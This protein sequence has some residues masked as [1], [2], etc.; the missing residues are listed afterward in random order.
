MRRE[1]FRSIGIDDN[2]FELLMSLALNK[3]SSVAALQQARKPFLL[4]VESLDPRFLEI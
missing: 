1:N 3:L 2:A 4:Q